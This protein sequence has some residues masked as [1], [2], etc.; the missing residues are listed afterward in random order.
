MIV[1]KHNLAKVLL[2]VLFFLCFSFLR[3]YLILVYP[4]IVLALMF[5]FNLKLNR[6]AIYI[7]LISALI[8]A[9]SIIYNGFW[10]LN[11]TLSL[12]ILMPSLV[13]I[14]AK[15]DLESLQ[16]F[17]FKSQF[18]LRSSQILM[19]VNITA[20]CTFFYTHLSHRYISAVPM[21][22]LDD[23]FYGFFGKEGLGAHLLSV[24]NTIFSV[25]YLLIKKYKIGVLFAFFSIL[26]FYGLGLIMAIISL[27]IT[28]RKKII[29]RSSLKFVFSAIFLLIFTVLVIRTVNVDNYNYIKGTLQS[30]VDITDFDYDREIELANK[31]ET[32]QIPRKI[33]FTVGVFRRIK[34]NP[35]ILLWGTSPGTY[36][37]R[38]AF[39]LNGDLSKTK[40]L[41]E[42]VK[43][44]PPY[45]QKDIYPLF[46]SITTRVPWMGGTRNQPFSSLIALMIEYG[47]LL[48]LLYGFLIYK[49]YRRIV[50]ANRNNLEYY[51]IQFI[52][53]Y[54]ILSSFFVYYFEL[55]EFILPII[56]MFKFYE[57][58]AQREKRLQT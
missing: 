11:N 40:V 10:V 50:K 3:K 54:T 33:T 14:L 37:S 34:E 42:N 22:V 1:K 57:F 55:I 31:F 38:T 49:L 58:S 41:R 23:A 17:E 46:N 9:I 25:R 26:G 47:F 19:F 24:L 4:F 30:F 53:I 29:S 20:L 13:L 12:F 18:W 5:F 16:N 15:Q 35:E 28:F 36:N 27:G 48:F 52:F 32:T 43:K 21:D 7:V 39:L 56:L 45:H 2:W 44:R 6:S 51:P 8:I